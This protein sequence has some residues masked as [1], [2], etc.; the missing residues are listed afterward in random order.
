M[1]S[2]VDTP[3]SQMVGKDIYCSLQH[4][5]LLTIIS[6]I[7]LLIHL[8]F[9]PFIF[10]VSLP[11]ELGCSSVLEHFLNHAR[12]WA[13]SSDVQSTSTYGA[14]PKL[15]GYKVLC[16]EQPGRKEL[17]TAGVLVLEEWTHT[18]WLQNMLYWHMWSRPLEWWLV[19]NGYSCSMENTCAFESPAQGTKLAMEVPLWSLCHWQ[20]SPW[21]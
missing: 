5:E 7:A 19:L 4:T 21:G 10:S 13:Q 8:N 20:F 17:Q 9:F 1:Y 3:F 14:A 18:V 6:T 15:E 11:S 2:R 16:K 12:P